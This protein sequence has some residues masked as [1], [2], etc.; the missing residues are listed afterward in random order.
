MHEDITLNADDA[1]ALLHAESETV[2]QYARSGELPGTRIGKSWV[3]MRDDVIAFLRK[4]IAHD[5]A[6]RLRTKVEP[7]AVSLQSKQNSRRRI[8]PVLPTSGGHSTELPEPH[9]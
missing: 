8:P 9:R 3:F 5:T 7:L 4:Q 2:L 1:A 6:E